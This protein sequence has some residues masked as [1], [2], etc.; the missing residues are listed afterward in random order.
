MPVISKVSAPP[1]SLTIFPYLRPGYLCLDMSIIPYLSL[2]HYI[3][4]E[5]KGGASYFGDLHTGAGQRVI[6]Q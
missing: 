5:K 3:F 6:V 4:L 1:I 2:K